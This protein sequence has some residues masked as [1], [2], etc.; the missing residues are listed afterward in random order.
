MQKE[1]DNL[2]AQFPGKR[3]RIIDL[4]NTSEDF[5]TLCEDYWQSKQVL[6][7]SRGTMMESSLLEN[8][9]TVLCIEL[10]KEVLRFIALGKQ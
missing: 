6:M 3:R 9:Y 7:K 4:F 5:R 1:L 10:E 8:E 2:I